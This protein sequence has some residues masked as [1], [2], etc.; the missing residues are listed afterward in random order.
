MRL[1]YGLSALLALLPSSLRGV[2]LSN[3]RADRRGGP[4]AA[5]G[6]PLLLGARELPSGVERQDLADRRQGVVVV[7][8]ADTALDH[9]A[10]G[11]VDVDDQAAPEVKAG[12]V[13]HPLLFGDVDLVRPETAFDVL[14]GAHR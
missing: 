9:D 3:H 6:L 7:E 8:S 10:A 1:A 4:P 11:V 2:I 13:A 12:V 5:T 14:S